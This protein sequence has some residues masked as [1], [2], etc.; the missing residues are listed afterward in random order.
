MTARNRRPDV[1]KEFVGMWLINGKDS[2]FLKSYLQKSRFAIIFMFVDPIG[3][4][5]M[6]FP[7]NPD[8]AQMAKD[9]K[10][11]LKVSQLGTCDGNRPKALTGWCRRSS[12][13]SAQ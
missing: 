9:I 4:L 10:R 11:L 7:K 3:N 6:R 2:D 1:T 13:P 12:F 5:M 8:P